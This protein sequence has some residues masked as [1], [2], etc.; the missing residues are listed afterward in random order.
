LPNYSLETS[1]IETYEVITKDISFYVADTPG[2]DDT[3]L[4]DIDV[5]RRVSIWMTKTFSSGQ[6]LS[7]IVYL[8]PITDTRLR[9]SSIRSLRLFDKLC[10][11][12]DRQNILLVTSFWN[13][14]DKKI[15]LSR[16]SQ[17]EEHEGFWKTLK[18]RGSKTERLGRD[19][20]RF[21]IVLADMAR[22]ASENFANT[23][24]MFPSDGLE[25]AI[26]ELSIQPTNK[27]LNIPEGI[28][29]LS[30]SEQQSLDVNSVHMLHLEQTSRLQE[31]EA[32]NA[33]EIE[34]K[35]EQLKRQKEMLEKTEKERKIR[36]R[37]RRKELQQDTASQRFEASLIQRDRIDSALDN[38]RVAYTNGNIAQG[39]D[40]VELRGQGMNRIDDSGRVIANAGVTR[41]V[42][43]R[44]CDGCRNPLGCQG[45]NRTYTIISL[46]TS[47]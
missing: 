16:E 2:F 41:S 20:E 36:E 11:G 22:N 32:S 13:T 31:L 18:E 5:I 19:Y 27:S 3:F 12:C 34:A 14:V 15:G 37:K 38:L 30:P 39:I 33:R 45:L 25:K 26:A 1:E 46:R 7:G 44:W 6:R 40:G 29:P 21:K 42:L 43:N 28:S 24:S 23:T 47:F 8:H 35:K 17:L 9:G 4:C 10:G